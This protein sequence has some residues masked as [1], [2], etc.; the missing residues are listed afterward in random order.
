MSCRISFSGLWTGSVVRAWFISSDTEKSPEKEP[1]PRFCKTTLFFSCPQVRLFLC[2]ALMASFQFRAK[3]WR[4]EKQQEEEGTKFLK[5]SINS[6]FWGFV[7][8]LAYRRLWWADLLISR[9]FCWHQGSV[10]FWL[11]SPCLRVNFIHLTAQTLEEP[12]ELWAWLW[13]SGEI[14]SQRNSKGCFSWKFHF[15][16]RALNSTS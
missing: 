12:A 2:F 15:K 3:Y 7:H 13:S 1:K 11:F 5:N 16:T 14:N 10:L 8:C 4:A 6:V 9:V